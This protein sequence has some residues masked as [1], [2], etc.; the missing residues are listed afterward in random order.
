LAAWP[1]YVISLAFHVQ[2]LNTR[3]AAKAI[4]EKRAASVT[5]DVD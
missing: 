5:T 4:R 1:H 2:P 3:A